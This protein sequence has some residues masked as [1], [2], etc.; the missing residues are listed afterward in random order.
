MPLHRADKEKKHASE[1]DDRPEVKRSCLA[2][3]TQIAAQIG[4]NHGQASTRLDSDAIIVR[5]FPGFVTS[6]AE[7]V[8][9][10]HRAC[11]H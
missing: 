10:R 6:S 8:K 2:A 4:A 1:S 3:G 5:D 11:R 9:S 7:R